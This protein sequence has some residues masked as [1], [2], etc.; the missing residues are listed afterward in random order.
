MNPSMPYMSSPNEQVSVQIFHPSTGDTVGVN[1]SKWLLDIALDATSS[2]SNTLL[3]A[4]NGYT[5]GFVAPT[6]PTFKLGQANKYAPGLVVLLNTTMSNSATPFRGPGTNL[7]ALFQINDARVVECDTIIEIWNS[8]FVGLPIA[9]DGACEA[10][11]FVVNGT[12]PG[13][14][15]DYSMSALNGR[16]DLISS[17]S[18]VS[19][20]AVLNKPPPCFIDAE[21][22]MWSCR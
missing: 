11:V 14:V 3:S 19:L 17:V 16:A 8:W 20:D 12:A 9:G 22:L 6:S 4:T 21:F 7:A 2:T 5:S 1:G 10:T 18:T 15:S 13:Y